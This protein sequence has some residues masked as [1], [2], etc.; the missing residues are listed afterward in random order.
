MTIQSF[1]H[2]PL[3]IDTRL[4]YLLWWTDGQDL[5]P[6]VTTAT[7]TG[8][9]ILGGEDTAILFGGDSTEDMKIA[10]ARGSRSAGGSIA[11]S[12]VLDATSTLS[13]SRPTVLRFN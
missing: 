7:G 10:A 2:E 1:W 3:G 8:T 5:P 13:K 11:S 6:L 12:A 4:E 9:G